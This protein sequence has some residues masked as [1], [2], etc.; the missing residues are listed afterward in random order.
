MADR[1]IDEPS[2][3]AIVYRTGYM[4]VDIAEQFQRAS[5]T[6]RQMQEMWDRHVNK[7]DHCDPEHRRQNNDD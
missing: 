7:P 3:A 5:D 2:D 1:K 4:G 6:S